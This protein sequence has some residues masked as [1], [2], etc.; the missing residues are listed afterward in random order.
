M[1]GVPEPT[2]R[3]WERRYGIPSPKRTGSGYR[4][5]SAKDVEQAREMRALCAGGMAAADAAKLLLAAID[6]APPK[7][8][9]GEIDP[10]AAAIDEFLEAVLRF[11]DEA[12]DRQ[13]RRLMFMG[14]SMAI[15]DRVLTPVL[16]EIGKRWHDGE[17]SVAQ[18]HLASQRLSTVLRDLLGLSPGAD[19]DSR[20][21]LACFAED[22]HELGLLG[23]AIRFSSWGFRP[24]FLGARTPPGAVHSAVEAVSPVLVALSVTVTPNRARARE[25]LDDYAVACAGVPWVVGGGGVGPI[26]EMVRSRGGVVAPESSAELRAIVKK[27]SERASKT[28]SQPKGKG[29]GKIKTP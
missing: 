6:D 17:L 29:K 5:Y 16:H 7:A 9:A 4:L 18:E 13:M 8:T 14:T 11:D 19:S 25:L 23:T 24:I 26:A 20:V 27:L 2:L 10:Y 15:L 3:A 1:T 12:L 22:D 21:L 28:V